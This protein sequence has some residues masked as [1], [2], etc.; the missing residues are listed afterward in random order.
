MLT[1]EISIQQSQ[2]VNDVSVINCIIQYP[3]ERYMETTS[4][5]TICIENVCTFTQTVWYN[6]DS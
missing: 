5:Y 3:S 2:I 4:Y 1:P 6:L